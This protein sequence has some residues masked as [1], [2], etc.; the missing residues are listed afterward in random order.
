MYWN[1]WAK[2]CEECD[3]QS[4]AS[5]STLQI[6]QYLCEV[7]EGG[8][9]VAP[10]TVAAFRWIRDKLGIQSL[11]LT[12]PMVMVWSQPEAGHMSKQR[13]ALNPQ[14]LEKLISL[15]RANIGTFGTM[16]RSVLKVLVS[17]LR[18]E[19]GRLPHGGLNTRSPPYYKR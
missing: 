6:A 3:I 10:S 12:S 11:A 13:P 15:A 9:T 17:G 18:Y 16:A 5:A 2:F 19:G 8:P 4:P 7:S 1:R 14:Q